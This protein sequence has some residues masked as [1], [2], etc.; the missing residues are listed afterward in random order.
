MNPYLI[1]IDV[2][3]TGAKT[4]VFRADGAAQGSGYKEYSL[5]TAGREVTQDA[6]DWWQ[7]V[8]QSVCEATRG[9]DP[10][11][12]AGIGISAQGAS[13]TA[14]DREFRPLCPVMTWMDSR[15]QQ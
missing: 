1:G 6:E 4:V 11:E 2:G 15:A 13:M 3:T 12:I 10:Q 7:A 5:Q 9:L 14:V 8:V